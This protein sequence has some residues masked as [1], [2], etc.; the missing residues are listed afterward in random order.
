MKFLL[1][2]AK[3]MDVTPIA[4]VQ[5]KTVPHFIAQAEVLHEVLKKKNPKQLQKL[6]GISPK[7][8]EENWE[9][10]Q[11]WTTK[12]TKE[13]GLQAFMIFRGEVYRGF[14]AENIPFECYDY[15]EEN[16]KILSGMYGVLGAFDYIMPYR[17]E[18]GTKLKY[19][20]KENLYE[21]WG[22][23]LT[24]YFNEIMQENE[25]L[26]DLASNEYTKVLNKKQLKAR[27]LELVF[28]DEREG[29]L[30]SI[31]TYFKHARGAMMR[32]CA[33]NKVETL[34][35]LQSLSVDGY[36]YSEAHSTDH[37]WI[38]VKPSVQ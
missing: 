21:Y 33:I 7:L 12:P 24:D 32:A 3:M 28:K 2:P 5:R 15:L 22:D 14:E 27:W 30:R 1:S 17:L 29:K 6:M 13:E 4:D 18:M 36:T 34:E 11:K 19:R 10:N 35:E 38:Y 31:M 9:R 16:M 23:S 37:K 20:R 26:V 8:A 25:V